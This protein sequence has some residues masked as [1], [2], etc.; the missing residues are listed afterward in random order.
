MTKHNI[1]LVI[2]ITKKKI[3]MQGYYQTIKIKQYMFRLQN[4]WIW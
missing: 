4:F 2:H 3:L 1:Y